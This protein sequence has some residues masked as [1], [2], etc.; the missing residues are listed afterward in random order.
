M[1]TIGNVVHVDDTSTAISYV[2]NWQ[3][4]T[5]SSR[6][7][8]QTVHDT[9]SVGAT[10]TL[11]WRGTQ[12]TIIGTIP[13]GTGSTIS[14]YQLDNGTPT[15]VT[16]QCGPT[17]AFNQVFWDSGITRDGEHM[18][19]IKNEG[20]TAD[21]QLDEIDY[22]MSVNVPNTN[23]GTSSGN[24]SSTA[25]TS[26]SSSTIPPASSSALSGNS[27]SSSTSSISASYSVTN[28]SV[29]S[30]LAISSSTTGE[31][32]V[33]VTIVAHSPLQKT[34][35]PVGAI[36]GGVVGGLVVILSFLLIFL[37]WHRR[38]KYRSEAFNEIAAITPFDV[39]NVS[40][41]RPS[42]GETGASLRNIDTQSGSG[43]FLTSNGRRGGQTIG[44]GL[45]GS[46]TSPVTTQ[47]DKGP[48][49][50][51]SIS[52]NRSGHTTNQSVNWSQWSLHPHIAESQTNS[53]VPSRSS[54]F[55]SNTRSPTASSPIRF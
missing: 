15:T 48:S 51:P 27:E 20:T 8:K 4:F 5:G 49:R 31:A 45:Y 29:P 34:N 44:E 14:S 25:T 32:T 50:F 52:R 30:R 1:E 42:V 23:S 22:V 54:H 46:M 6:Q 2:G 36:V 13:I 53:L 47:M 26:S 21:F 16:F 19:V 7:W 24:V 10:A 11:N 38:Q 17:T 55:P 28:S 18:L 40:I 39:T 9:S 12:V 3:S 41:A 35:T 33:T 43:A 37:C